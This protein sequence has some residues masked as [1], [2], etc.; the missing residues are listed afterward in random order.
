MARRL[1]S[2]VD[3]PL[4]VEIAD[5][6]AGA[7]D[8]VRDVMQLLLEAGKERRPLLDAIRDEAERA[9][10][11]YELA[12]RP[13]AIDLSLPA[14]LNPEPDPRVALAAFRIAQESIANAL[15]HGQATQIRVSVDV[16]VEHVIV[17]VED[18]G[19]GFDAERALD[20][21]T[22]AGDSFGLIGMSARAERLDGSFKVWSRPGYTRV[23]TVLPRVAPHV[24]ALGRPPAGWPASSSS[25]AA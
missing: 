7:L 5:S 23:L 10:R 13:V 22:P 1:G 8:E 2:E 6:L 3:S 4:L 19:V 20:P 25:H 14:S 9:R 21:E 18:D 11:C 15:R 12:L 16:D 24:G 17:T